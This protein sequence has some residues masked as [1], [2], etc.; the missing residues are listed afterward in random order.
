MPR[1]LIASAESRGTIA[2]VYL[3]LDNGCLHPLYFDHRLFWAW[4][5]TTGLRD[6]DELVGMELEFGE[7]EDGQQ[8]VGLPYRGTA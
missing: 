6:P 8:V 4:F 5:H 2:G 3:R 1:G 7:S